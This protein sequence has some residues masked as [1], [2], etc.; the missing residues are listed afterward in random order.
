MGIYSWLKPRRRHSWQFRPTVVTLEDR[1]VP[2]AA[3]GFFG[4]ALIAP[5]PATHLEVIVPESTRAGKTFDVIVQAL[6]ASNQVATGYEGTVALSLGTP[7]AG[8]VL[9]TLYQFTA[10]DYG[11]HDFHVS[12]PLTAPEQIV[13]TDSVHGGCQR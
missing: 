10:N 5:G 6:D 8:A 4:G 7:E 3:G 13:A 11:I 1:T 12:L 2:S 9:P